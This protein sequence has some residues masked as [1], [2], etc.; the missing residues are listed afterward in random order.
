MRNSSNN[1]SGQETTVVDSER[2]KILARAYGLP[3]SE[4]AKRAGIAP[5]TLSR[6]MENHTSPTLKTLAKI[7]EALNEPLTGLLTLTNRSDQISTLSNQGDRTFSLK[8][9]ETTSKSIA[10]IRDQLERLQAQLDNIKT[11]LEV[12]NMY[13]EDKTKIKRYLSH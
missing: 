12:T 7:A 3:L 8:I 6:I 13:N 1:N 11:A 2:I 10:E 5:S 4:I 9:I